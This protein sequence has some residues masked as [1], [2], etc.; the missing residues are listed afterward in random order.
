MDPDSLQRGFIYLCAFGSV[1][2]FVHWIHAV[3]ADVRDRAAL[4][5]ERRQAISSFLLL[6]VAP[7]AHSLGN[8]LG[9]KIDRV[10]A[11]SRATGS[12]SLIVSLRS[13]AEHM[14]VG[15]GRPHGLTPNEFMGLWAVARIFG[16]L[17]GA[18]CYGMLGKYFAGIPA[19]LLIPFLAVIALLPE[20]FGI[21]I[22]WGIVSLVLA[23]LYFT[24]LI[25]VW[26]GGPTA[27]LL[28]F[29][30]L[31]YV[32]PWLWLRDRERAR[33]RAI[34]RDLPFA[35]DL[36]TLS[37]EAGLDFTAALGRIVNR[38][39]N[40]PL[41][42]ELAETLRQIQMGVPRA[43]ALRDLH[44]RV[45]MEEIF[46]VTSALIQADELGA[47]LGP[48][49]RVQADTFRTRRAQAAEKAAMEAPVKLLFPLIC[50]FFPAT[51]IVIFG[52]IV[53]RFFLG[54]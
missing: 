14:L 25:Y 31:G 2:L 22:I 32:L 40:S 21:W 9:P 39:P 43:E 23:V 49:L 42:Q 50:F 3:W 52:P 30:A 53:I 5:E 10:E 47:S 38:R 29:L 19:P 37:V 6:L 35:L 8:W 54:E 44:D 20:L 11:E 1:A 45:R 13:K 24:L 17:L 33:K 12:T 26:P 16:A 41:S 15:A 34:R 48:I 7:L 18:L 51:F 46:S 36:L 27:V 28:P 4:A